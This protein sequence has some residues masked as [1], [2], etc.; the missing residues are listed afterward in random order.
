MADVQ[1][2]RLGK[3]SEAAESY[4]KALGIDPVNPKALRALV[5]FYTVEGNWQSLIRVY[6]NALRARPRGEPEIGMLIQ[7]GMLWWKKLG[8]LD[9][10]DEYWK[11]VRKSEPA[12][13]AMVEF[14]RELYKS[15]A[16]KLLPVLQQAQKVEQD[17][18]RRFDLSVEMARLADTGGT[19]EKAIELWKGVLKSEP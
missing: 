3:R 8:N 12:H 11:K 15:D 9:S 14:Y 16:A 19:V 1:A 5:D 18:K 17:P 13:P 2:K 6:E 4:K 10:A 7:I